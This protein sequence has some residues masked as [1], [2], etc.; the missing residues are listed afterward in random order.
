MILCFFSIHPNLWCFSSILWSK[1]L[2]PQ[3]ELRPTRTIYV[4]RL[5]TETTL[6]MES[7]LLNER[8]VERNLSTKA[9]RKRKTLD[10]E[11]NKIK[12]RKLVWN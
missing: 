4:H 9:S 1:Q 7:L 11:N 10:A 8:N 5:L 12:I 2:F 3:I 6:P